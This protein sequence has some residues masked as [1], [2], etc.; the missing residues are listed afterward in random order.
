MVADQISVSVSNVAQGNEPSLIREWQRGGRR[1]GKN[2]YLPFS[3]RFILW[4]YYLYNCFYN[5]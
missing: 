3:I 5:N 1:E 4:Y 2:F